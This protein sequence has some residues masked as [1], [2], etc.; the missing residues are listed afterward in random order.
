MSNPTDDDD[1]PPTRLPVGSQRFPP[2]L[3]EAEQGRRSLALVDRLFDEASAAAEEEDAPPDARA[4]RL[5]AFGRRLADQGLARAVA[6]ERFAAGTGAPDDDGVVTSAVRG[7]DTSQI[8]RMDRARLEQ[9]VLSLQRGRGL[10]PTVTF[11]GIED[12]ELVQL[13]RQLR[14]R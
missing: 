13:A 3:D 10:T 12:A 1:L 2:T 6:R 14:T 11:E 8:L 5:A 7:P 9:L 4:H